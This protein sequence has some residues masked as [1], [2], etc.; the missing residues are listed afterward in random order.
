[1]LGHYYNNV[2]YHESFN[3]LTAIDIYSGKNEKSLSKREKIKRQTMNLRRVQNLN[4]DLKN[5]DLEY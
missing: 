3:N 5:K 4:N 1:M 2:R